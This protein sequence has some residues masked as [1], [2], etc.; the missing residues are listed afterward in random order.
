[1]L[2][3]V[4]PILLALPVLL[5]ATAL[6]SALET[7]LFSLSYHDRTRLRKQAPRAE[8]AAAVLLSNPRG[9]LVIV[10]F[11]TTIATTLYAV[12]TTILLGQSENF[13]RLLGIDGEREHHVAKLVVEIAVAAFNVLAMTVLAEVVSKMLAG[14]YRVT[15][16]RALAQPALVVYQAMSPLRVILDRG[17]VAPLTRLFVPHD[18]QRQEMRPEELSELLQLGE[19]SGAI[20]ADEQRVLRQV[21]QLGALRVREVMTPRVELEWIDEAG[22][23]DEVAEL[24]KRSRLTRVPVCK[25]SLDDE[26]VGL[27][28]AKKYLSQ[29]A[30]GLRPTL[31]QCT[32]PATFIP[33]SA[34]LDKLLDLM[35]QGGVKLA[36]IV[37]EFGGVVGAVSATDIVRRLISELESDD[38]GAAQE[39]RV[40]QIEPGRWS[41]PG[42][43]SVREWARMF[44]INQRW[45]ASTVSGLIFAQLGRVPKVGDVARIDNLR[46]KVLELDGRVAQRVL[47][48]IEKEPTP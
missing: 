37:D 38:L 19:K 31:A 40:E 4:I 13:V 7:S 2:W 45:R 41:V 20:D 29:H 25:G 24:V 14:R 21:I 48:W 42:R 39:H 36:L 11:L 1:M 27:L 47:V 18:M 6:L 12:L 22:T 33:Q 17:V 23:R 16:V 5:I 43:L 15:V 3:S 34:P 46:L 35:R 8:Q 10:L 30:M 32:D 9:L 44:N 28:D 26:I